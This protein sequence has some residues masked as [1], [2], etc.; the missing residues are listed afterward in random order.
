MTSSTRL[1][2]YHVSMEP[3]VSIFKVKLRVIPNTGTTHCHNALKHDPNRYSIYGNCSCFLMDLPVAEN[4]GVALTK[5][6][7][8]TAKHM[9]LEVVIPTATH[10]HAHTTNHLALCHYTDEPRL[11][12]ATLYTSPCSLGTPQT[13]ARAPS[14]FALRYLL[15]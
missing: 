4:A 9:A 13:H 1:D 14:F 2:T 3:A 10:Y 5:N 11:C 12:R 8:A 6:H 7:N 15:A